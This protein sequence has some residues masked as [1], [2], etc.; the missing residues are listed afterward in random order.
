MADNLIN[1]EILSISAAGAK[2]DL[3]ARYEAVLHLSNTDLY[4]P[5]VESVDI[6]RDYNVNQFD[7]V[8][9]SFL[10]PLGDITKFVYPEKDSLEITL[11]NHTLGAIIRTRYDFVMT[12]IDEHIKQHNYNNRKQTDLNKEFSMI[13]GQCV[14][15]DIED[16]TNTESFGIYKDTT[17]SDIILSSTNV[18][19]NLSS[20]SIINNY[21]INLIPVNNTR[22]YKQI[23]VSDNINM[24][25]L[26][27]YLQKN[28]G[29]YNGHIGSYFQFFD[30]SKTFFVYPLF[31]NDLFLHSDNTLQVTLTNKSE[32]QLL[33]STYAYSGKTLKILCSKLNKID[34]VGESDIK[35]YGTNLNITDT[36]SINKRPI[37][38]DKNNVKAE[39]TQVKRIMTHKVPKN[40][41]VKRA[42]SVSTSNNYEERSKV[43]KNDFRKMMVEWRISNARL[44]YPYMGITV[45]I[46]EDGYINTY[47]GMLTGV[48]IVTDNIS[49][50][51]VSVL[52]LLIS[53]DPIKSNIIESNKSVSNTDLF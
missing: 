9:I 2:K 4:I 18:L 24:L 6:I 3:T 49:K 15:V 45:I 14:P 27:E 50:T 30:N 41:K 32:L 5:I 10:L 34:D 19:N 11:I 26:P 44:L 13:T 47:V 46:E 39:N 52:S 48:H 21:D 12:K 28:F 35:N 8:T 33:D 36:T 29:V 7:Y 22:K 43:L 1:A 51:E 17:V 31:R 23:P 53:I 20:N 25:E 37:T 40:N 38:V 42:S 16:L